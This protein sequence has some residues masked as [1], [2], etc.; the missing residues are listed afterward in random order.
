MRVLVA[1]SVSPFSGREELHWIQA[2]TQ[3]VKKKNI[4]VDMFMLPF[5]NNPLLLPDQMMSLRLM[6]VESS[7]DLLLT[8]GHP[9]FVLKHPHKRVLLFSLAS[10]L[11][12]W[13]DSEYGVLSTPQYQSIRS[14]VFNAEKNCLAEADKIICASLTLASIIK[15]EYQLN[16]D[17]VILDDC[18]IDSKDIPLPDNGEWVTCES[19]LEPS[20]RIDLLLNSVALSKEQWRLNIFVPSGSDV[21]YQ[22][23]RQ[24]IDR[25]GLN[26]RVYITDGALAPEVLKKSRVFIALTFSTTRIPECAIRAIKMSVPVV[27]ASDCGS[28][29]EIITNKINGFVVEPSDRGIAYAI[30][31][32]V[33]DNK[34]QSELS[35][36]SRQ[37][38][39]KF[40][41]IDNVIEGLMG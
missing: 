7:C 18:W 39:D 15:T 3:G 22:A 4:Q 10:S 24:R 31:L 40:S 5:V 14:S 26:R 11:H 29:L 1:G 13:F 9:A 23:L 32:I 21:Y 6:D 25:L 37:S 17:G 19:T 41:N 35:Q 20:D 28:L 30:D 16:T 38:I 34:L 8:I 2:I 36:G 33:A 12:E 27:T